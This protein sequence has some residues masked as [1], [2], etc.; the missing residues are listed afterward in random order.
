MGE[1][2]E[3]LAAAGYVVLKVDSFGPRGQ[4]SVC[5]RWT[6]TVDQVAADALAAAAHLRKLPFVDGDRI[7]VVGFSYGAMAGLR[8]ASASYVKQQKNPT[9]F[10][11]VVGFYPWCVV[12]SPAAPPDIV[13]LQDNFRDDNTTPVHLFLG[14]QDTEA[15]SGP[16]VAHAERV[17]RAGQ[18]VSYTVFPDATHGFDVDFAPRGY[19]LNKPAVDAATSQM[20]EFLAREMR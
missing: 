15:P 14:G 2:A 9:P 13:A 18:P 19:H 7:A 16:C 6:V 10:R 4:R 17:K 5:D 3:T 1:W 12:M 8:L 20:L 11:A